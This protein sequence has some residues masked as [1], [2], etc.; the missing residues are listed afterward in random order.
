[1]VGVGGGENCVGVGI[2]CSVGG[3]GVVVVDCVD[4]FV[5]GFG[6]R[7]DDIGVLVFFG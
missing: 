4:E 5:V 1:M 7:V 6:E 2:G 3:G